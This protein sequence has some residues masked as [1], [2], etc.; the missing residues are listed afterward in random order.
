MTDEVTAAIDKTAIE[1]KIVE[2]LAAQ[3]II[4][5]RGEDVSGIELLKSGKLDSLGV[6][7]LTMFLGEQFDL[8]IEDD[9]FVPENLATVGSLADLVLRKSRS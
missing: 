1:N 9:D 5:G 7:Q 2:F 4:P 6:I 3:L 8:E